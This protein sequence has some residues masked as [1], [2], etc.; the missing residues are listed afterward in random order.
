M[1]ISAQDIEFINLNPQQPTIND[2]VRDLVTECAWY[3]LANGVVVFTAGIDLPTQV[4]LETRHAELVSGWTAA[5]Y[6]RNRA[7]AF[8][9]KSIAEQL[10]M[11]YWDQVDSTTLWRDWVAGIK[12]AY[13]KPAP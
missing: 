8:A 1:P 12:A 4:E 3:V 2:A 7:A 10:D 9:T 11:I 13:P 5:E 6:K